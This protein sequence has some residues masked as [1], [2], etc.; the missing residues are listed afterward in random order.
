M[1]AHPLT[2]LDF[3]L[4]LFL[5]ICK[6]VFLIFHWVNQNFRKGIHTRNFEG[7]IFSY[8]QYLIKIYVLDVRSFEVIFLILTHFKQ[9]MAKYTS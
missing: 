1:Y 2:E 4:R 3:V 6:F 8:D 7:C 9:G 5:R